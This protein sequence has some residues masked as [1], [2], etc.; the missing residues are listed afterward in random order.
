[1]EISVERYHYPIGQGIFSA[2]IVRVDEKEYVCVYDC[3]SSSGKA[4]ISTY[5]SELYEK[6]KPNKITK[7]GKKIINLLVISHLDRDHVNG[8]P[9][10]M[11]IFNIRKI[12]IPY[13]S[14]V[15]KIIFAWTQLNA[16]DELLR[17]GGLNAHSL[18]AGLISEVRDD[19]TELNLDLGSIEVVESSEV[20][21][22]EY[23]EI[24]RNMSKATQDF[25]RVW[26]FLHFS[27]YSGKN[28]SVKNDFIK[29]FNKGFHSVLGKGIDDLDIEDFQ[30]TKKRENIKSVYGLACKS[31]ES[32]HQ[33]KVEDIFNASSII[34]Y[35][36]PADDLQNLN[37][38][39]LNIVRESTGQQVIG[40]YMVPVVYHREKFS[41]RSCDNNLECMG[42]WLGTGDAL[43]NESA[44]IH[45]LKANLGGERISRVQVLTVPHHG[46][47]KNSDYEFY[48][49]FS[50][51]GIECIVQSN[52]E[53]THRHPHADV[54]EVITRM[55]F[56]EIPVTKEEESFYREYL[57]LDV[58]EGK[59]RSDADNSIS[60]D[61]SGTVRARRDTYN[62]ICCR[63]RGTA[64][65]EI[66]ALI[67]VMREKG[68][69]T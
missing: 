52:P 30:D 67:R 19:G 28:E 59:N 65:G 47:S 5:A 50:Q 33:I 32:M 64:P 58:G 55:G 48:D 15:E 7:K 34:L 22:V 44:N 11:K 38:E 18:L 46:S 1:M 36:G 14:K 39:S 25:H 41:H 43:L 56:V 12:V 37:K 61:F 68:Q 9:E 45:E 27:L 35:S 21:S 8:I 53:Y 10:L 6:L 3:G 31:V 42:G 63:A 4:N 60:T 2:Q 29:E 54:K 17:R 20:A 26:E 23:L 51:N 66:M 13:M 57:H 49:V 62:G 16:G 69:T 24:N 40:G